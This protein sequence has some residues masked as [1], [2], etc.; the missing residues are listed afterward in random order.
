[1]YGYK[2]NVRCCQSFAR[3]SHTPTSATTLGGVFL[4]AANFGRPTNVFW[5]RTICRELLELIMECYTYY[6][7]Y[8]I[9]LSFIITLADTTEGV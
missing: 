6:I 7:T 3:A 2:D 4:R 1:M 8:H 5:F 9:N